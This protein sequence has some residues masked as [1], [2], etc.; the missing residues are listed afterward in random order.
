MSQ[1]RTAFIA[2]GS[3]L[4]DRAAHL[5]RA[6]ASLGEI[7]GVAVERATEAEET[8]PLG[9]LDQPPYLNAMV[10]VRTTL[11]PEMLLAVCHQIERD[12]G[13]VRTGKWDSR[14]I[15]LDLVMMEGV[16]SDRPELTLPHP[17]LPQRDFWARE[18]AELAADV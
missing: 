8:A 2:L 10:R 13:R 1:P 15:D 3:N 11:S 18:L 9:G 5:A 4:G 7:P 14:T 16:R 12:A 6:I 17:G